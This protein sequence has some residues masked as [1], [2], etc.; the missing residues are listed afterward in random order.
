MKVCTF[1]D[2]MGCGDLTP[3]DEYLE[4]RKWIENLLG[5][6]VEYETESHPAYLDN[7]PVDIF[8]MDFGGM[9]PGCEDTIRSIYRELVRQVEEKPNTLF[10]LYSAFT[11]Q[12]YKEVMQ[13]VSPD[14]RDAHNVVYIRD[15]EKILKFINMGR[16]NLLGPKPY[17]VTKLKTPVK[18]RCA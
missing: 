17:K 3:E 4:I 12:W 6:P 14:L 2:F 10:I 18:R 16:E 8:I 9:L 7:K 11:E 13:M 1:V 15:E 5:I